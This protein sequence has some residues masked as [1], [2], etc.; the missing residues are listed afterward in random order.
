MLVNASIQMIHAITNLIY[1][2][3]FYGVAKGNRWNYSKLIDFKHHALL[4][5]A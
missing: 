2:I 5:R 3:S 1:A 4:V